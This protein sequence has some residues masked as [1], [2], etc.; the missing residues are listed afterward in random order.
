[1]KS[2]IRRCCVA[3]SSE[4]V[5][6]WSTAATDRR[7]ISA[8][9]SSPT[10]PLRG[11][12]VGVGLRPRARRPRRRG[13]PRPSASTALGLGVGVG[14]QARPLG[15]DVALG[16]ADLRRLGRR[17]R[18]CRR[19]TSSSSFWI[20]SVR[21]AIAFL[22]AGP[23]NFHSSGE[24]DQRGEAAVDDLGRLRQD[25]AECVTMWPSS[26][27]PSSSLGG[28][29][30]AEADATMPR[31]LIVPSPRSTTPVDDRRLSGR[32]PVASSPA[33]RRRRRPPR[34]SASRTAARAASASAAAAARC[35]ASRALTLRRCAAWRSASS[36]WRAA[37]MRAGRLGPDRGELGLVVGD[38]GLRLRRASRRRR[39]WPPRM[40]S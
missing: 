9:S 5:T 29:R 11:G 2:S 20:R 39:S 19:P 21:A 17:R 35:S 31:A 10:R 38:L 15:G 25:R 8:R 33:G 3:S 34:G 18:P 24:D 6:T 40:P 16:L 32:W 4:P 7:A 1:M 14:E 26:S 30:D 27:T 12:D 37:S 23:A 22:I 28:R 13:G 36:A